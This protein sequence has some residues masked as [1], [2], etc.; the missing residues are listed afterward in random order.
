[1]AYPPNHRFTKRHHLN[2]LNSAKSIIAPNFLLYNF[3]GWLLGM[4][5]S[6]HIIRLLRQEYQTPMII[7]DSISNPFIMSDRWPHLQRQ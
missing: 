3:K 7:D 4:G 5:I 6:T 1:M 2:M